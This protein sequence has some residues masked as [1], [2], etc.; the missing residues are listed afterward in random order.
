MGSRRTPGDRVREWRAREGVTLAQLS[1]SIGDRSGQLQ[2]WESGDRPTLPL[3]MK[4]GIAQRTGIALHLIVDRD[5]LDLAKTMV[6]LL[7][8][9]AAA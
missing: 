5:E 4:V 3:R 6:D 8:R 9:D 7:A 2:R 1:A